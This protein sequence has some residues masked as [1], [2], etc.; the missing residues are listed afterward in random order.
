[1]RKRA[2][3]RQRERN[4][5]LLLSAHLLFLPTLMKICLFFARKK[6]ESFGFVLL[7]F[8]IKRPETR[9]GMKM[10]TMNRLFVYSLQKPDAFIFLLH[11]SFI[12][13][14]IM[15]VTWRFTNIF[16]KYL[17]RKSYSRDITYVHTFILLWILFRRLFFGL[18]Q[19][20]PLVIIERQ[21]S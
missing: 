7:F 11:F 14:K 2:N 8:V 10:T 18:S 17:D 5:L 13:G 15:H 21:Y 19:S 3:K 1:M 9:N 4:T 16:M 20:I 6:E 12:P